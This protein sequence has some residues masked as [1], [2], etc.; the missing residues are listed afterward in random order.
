M[1]LGFGMNRTM[2]MREFDF[3]FVWG[4][5]HI[6]LE[7]EEAEKWAGEYKVGESPGAH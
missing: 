6:K 2:S 1:S 4:Y 7:F 5:Q 3:E